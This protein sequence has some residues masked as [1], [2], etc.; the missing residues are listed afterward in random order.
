M[1]NCSHCKK[2][3]SLIKMKPLPKPL[4]FSFLGKQ[5]NC[6]AKDRAGAEN[7]V[8]IRSITLIF[9]H[10]CVYLGTIFSFTPVKGTS[11]S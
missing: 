7:I 4:S 1:I 11:D 8:E 10:W 5:G 9:S 3:L 2:F 6:G